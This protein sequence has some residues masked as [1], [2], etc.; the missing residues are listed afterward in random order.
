MANVIFDKLTYVDRLKSAGIADKSARAHADALDVAMREGVTN[1]ADI[2]R[3]EAKLETAICDVKIDI[4]KMLI[5]LLLGQ[6]AL[7]AVLVRFFQ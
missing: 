5:P 3:L 6:A 2:Q 1:K 7:T 4:M